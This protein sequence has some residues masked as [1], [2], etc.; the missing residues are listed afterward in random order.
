MSSLFWKNVMDTAQ[1]VSAAPV[2]GESVQAKRCVI[3][4][5]HA[6]RSAAQEAALT[7]LPEM[8]QN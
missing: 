5:P 6:V 2:D 1:T 7:I 8:G 3:S 4:L